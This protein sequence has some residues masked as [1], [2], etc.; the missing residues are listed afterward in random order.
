MATTLGAAYI[1][2][3]PSMRGITKKIESA[4]GDTV[5]EIKPVLN[6]SFVAQTGGAM[7]TVG[8]H[9]SAL[10]GKLTKFVTV[11]ALGA[12]SAIGG[13]FTAG[14]SKRLIQIDT[15]Q[16]KLTALG[17]SG[18]EL[19]EVM[20]NAMA[21]VKGTSFGLGEAAT[22]ASTA[23]A[24]GVKSGKDL[25]KYLTSVG[26]AAAVAGCSMSDMGS[27]FNKVQASGRAYN[28]T[29][30]Q[31]SERGLPVY[32]YLSKKLNKTQDEIVKMAS[33]GQISSQMLREAIDEN[34]GGA[35][36]TMG[37]L[38]ITAAWAN[39]KA[40]IGRVGAAF[41]GAGDDAR[42]AF[43][44]I[45]TGINDVTKVVDT[46]APYALAA[47]QVLGAVLDGLYHAVVQLAAPIGQLISSI[48]GAGLDGWFGRWFSADDATK[49]QLIAQAAENI[50]G[51]IQSFAD[52]VQQNVARIQGLWD[53]LDAHTQQKLGSIARMLPLIA[54]GI[55]PAMSVAGGAIGGLGGALTVVTGK[56]KLF[57]GGLTAAASKGVTGFAGLGRGLMAA[58][59]ALGSISSAVGGLGGA[60][61]G[62]AL[63]IAAAVGAFALMVSQSP[64]L[65]DALGNGIGKI[66]GALGMAFQAF[67]P[68]LQ[69]LWSV[70]STQL[71]PPILQ[72]AGILGTMLAP[73]ISVIMT[74]IAAIIPIIAQVAAIIGQIL[75]AYISVLAGILQVVVAAF[76]DLW[77][78]LASF[79]VPIFQQCGSVISEFATSAFNAIMNFLK[80]ISDGI[81]NGLQAIQSFFSSAWENC[82]ALIVSA[83]NAMTNSISAAWNCIKNAV[84]NGI[85]GVMSYVS[86]LPSRI[87]GALSGLGGL[88]TNAGHQIM[89][90]FLNGLKAS[91]ERVKGFV[92]SVADWIAAHKGPKSY[93]LALLVPHGGWI[94]SGLKEGLERSFPSVQDAVSGMADELSRSFGY[95]SADVSMNAAGLSDS[96]VKRAT[97]AQQPPQ[98]YNFSVSGIDIA[99]DTPEKQSA[100]EMLMQP[101]LMQHRMGVA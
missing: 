101:I 23:M 76:S 71:L 39:L 15:A 54:V 86:S 51:S 25:E 81:S 45:K 63:P 69:Q 26:D 14:G 85:S 19:K 53:Q 77:N 34:I 35:A 32:D 20:N 70:F 72:L 43:D 61:G 92:S 30:Q 36:K 84:S 56:V 64:A 82:K 7:Q 16:A 55:G 62:L 41:L 47:G 93:D 80:G 65:Q 68:V 4:F 52:T 88:L 18:A 28:D 73:I 9:M 75:V 46:F 40:A 31:L 17:V 38:S 1:D 99:I 95:V 89:E 74:V 3:I 57:H 97:S 44:V 78:F 50:R 49:A 91:W 13:I 48:M 29:L 87:T 12:A 67:L 2:I 10:G 94:M 22:V 21:S 8:G 79:I 27:I 59:P 11:P 24:A 98:I 96:Q 60:L 42:G 58:F 66:V 83:W 33:Q 37:Q 90:G 100:L 6:E 5:P